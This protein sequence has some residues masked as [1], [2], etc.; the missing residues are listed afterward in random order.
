MI[1]LIFLLI[2]TGVVTLLYSLGSDDVHKVRSLT[3]FSAVL[4]TYGVCL[5]IEFSDSR[6]KPN[7]IDVYQGKTELEYTIRGGE[8]VDSVVV[9][10]KK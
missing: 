6:R 10:K 3:W 1:I 4:I 5:A 8:V 9:F 2:I 7:A